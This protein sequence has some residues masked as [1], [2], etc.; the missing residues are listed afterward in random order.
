MPED[1][2]HYAYA[3]FHSPT[4]RQRY[5]EFLKIDFP[6][7]PLTSDRELF[8]DLAAKGAELVRYHL[9]K[10]IGR[11]A[12]LTTFPISGDSTVAAQHPKYVEAEKRVYINKTQ[13]FEGIEAE[14]WNFYIG[15]YQV[16]EKWLKD[17]RDRVLTGDELLHYQKVVVALTNT[18]RLMD[19]ID[20]RIPAW[21]IT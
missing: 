1:I 6:R 8:R 17:R 19:E 14:V 2:F 10:D 4:Y 13:Y 20:E 11:S 15:G 16:L 5:D 21:P 3:V 9:L 12:L 7:L 18:I